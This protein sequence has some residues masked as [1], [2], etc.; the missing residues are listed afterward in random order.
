MTTYIVAHPLAGAMRSKGVYRFCG[1]LIGS[2]AALLLVPALANAPLLLSLAMSG[3]VAF[4]LYVSLLDRTPR[5]YLFMLAGYTAAFVG[6]PSVDA[7]Q[8]IFDTAVSRVEEIGLGILCAT[9]IHSVFWP[10]GL[11][12]SVLGLIDRALADARRWLGD[13]LDP[14]RQAGAGSDAKLTGDRRRLAGDITQLRLLSTHVPF[15]TTHLRWTAGAIRAMQDRVAALTPHLSAVDDRLRALADDQGRLPHDVVALLGQVAQWLQRQASDPQAAPDADLDAAFQ[16]FAAAPAGAAVDAAQQR[17]QQAL[18]ISLVQ[19]LA[20]LTAEWQACA[21]L[22][23]DIDAG[24]RGAA[25]PL[26]RQA[27]L[28]NR[29]LHRN[30]GMALLS[31][32]AAAIAIAVCCA[33]WIL[34][35][36]TYGYVAAMMAAV[37]CSFFA[38]L[39]DPVPAIH[40]FI[41]WTLWSV[42]VSALYVLVLL[43]LVQDFGML[44]AI[45]APLFLVLGCFIARPASFG[46]AMPF[47]FGVAGTLAMH[48]TASADL[49]SFVNF[50]AAQIMGALI[51]SRVTRLLRSVGAQW[52]ARRI[53]RATWRELGDMADAARGAAPDAG[54]AVRMLDRI[55]LLAPRIAQA[56]GTLDGVVANDALRDLRVGADL[57]TLRQLHV[58]L[59]AAVAQSIPALLA[60][61]SAFFRARAGG[62]AVAPPSQALAGI[63]AALVAAFQPAGRD[64]VADRAVAALVGL[65]RNLFPQAPA[66]L[67]AGTSTPGTEKEEASDDR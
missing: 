20:E 55:G 46:Q 48:D 6:F 16:R 37:F 41:K 56:G 21:S 61:I 49:A 58:D 53:Q 13:L 34:T 4:C 65:R 59:S 52:S 60:P 23:R 47:F 18:R 50:T 64:A 22:R 44:V 1:T 8:A 35:G 5:A 32:A 54:Y 57:A 28:G 36:W 14:E 26:R 67:V 39:D 38:A 30:R 40:G 19:R 15:D 62:Q 9:V 63:D 33:F 2:T 24:L 12:G 45:C 10:K 11:T 7:P 42:P 43:P 27:S 51:A 66:A 3:W 31:A 25:A 17:W 29:V